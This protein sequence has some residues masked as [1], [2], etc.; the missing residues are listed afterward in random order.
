MKASK[1][2]ILLCLAL[3]HNIHAG[4]MGP[5][6]EPLRTVLAL[7]LGPVWTSPGQAQTILLEP[8]FLQSYTTNRHDNT[9][10]GGEFFAGF[11]T[12]VNHRF[13]LQYGLA[14]AATS[15]ANLNG[16]I[17]QDADP[18]YD[19]FVYSYKVSHFHLTI[20]AKLVGN[21]QRFVQPYFS[22]SIGPGFNH[23]Y[24]YRSRPKIVE[25]GEELPFNSRTLAALTYTLGMGIQKSLNNHWAVGF[26]YEFS[27]W[28]RSQLARAF[29]QTV[30]KGL[31]LNHSF[32]HQLQ[33]NLS[34][35]V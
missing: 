12:A 7:S 11:Q 27:D 17:W 13:L 22:A 21:L 6:S 19:N 14:I 20:K 15:S 5:T 34:L 29:D 35:V 10:L 2:A 9:L 26:G 4:S 3:S 33:I 16:D 24:H 1:L 25:V 31:R 32:S 18:F 30:G 23:A 8:D 28:G